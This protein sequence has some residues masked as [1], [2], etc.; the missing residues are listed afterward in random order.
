MGKRTKKKKKNEQ[1]VMNF[2]VG[3]TVDWNPKRINQMLHPRGR[4]SG[5]GPFV[6]IDIIVRGKK[7]D[8]PRALRGRTEQVVR[9]IQ[10]ADLGKKENGEFVPSI[11]VSSSFLSYSKKK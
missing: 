3:D 7:G 5:K 2:S 6:V 11:D 4:F 9:I 1:E 8:D 10:K